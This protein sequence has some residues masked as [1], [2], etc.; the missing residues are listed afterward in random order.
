VAPSQARKRRRSDCPRRGSVPDA[1]RLRHRVSCG[2]GR[3]LSSGRP[4]CHPVF[5]TSGGK[6]GPRLR[7]GTTRVRDGRP[8]RQPK[9]G[10]RSAAE[11][12]RWSR[13]RPTIGRRAVRIRRRD[14]RSAPAMASGGS[15]GHRSR[16]LWPDRQESPGNPGGSG[17]RSRSRNR[18]KFLLRPGYA[19]LL[20][21]SMVRKGSSVRV[22]QRAM[23]KPRK[24]P[25]FRE[26]GHVREP[27]S[28]SA[29][30]PG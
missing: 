13:R 12:A 24:W 8:E 22:R 21:C 16:N 1:V 17:H 28:S 18:E 20:P 23:Q 7:F 19:R 6:G 2:A 3:R 9:R 15:T 29:Y 5:L 14:C 27:L 30:E 10:G 11:R 26:G 4:G 25:D